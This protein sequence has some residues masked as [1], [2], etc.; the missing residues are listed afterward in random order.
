MVWMGLQKLP[1]WGKS[2]SCQ[3]APGVAYYHLSPPTD[4]AACVERGKE[5][6]FGGFWWAEWTLV[7]HMRL[8]WPQVVSDG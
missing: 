2:P 8:G 1:V 4:S 3:H 5:V 6:T 7:W